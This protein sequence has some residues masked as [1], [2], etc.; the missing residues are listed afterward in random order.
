MKKT[1]PY[2][3]FIFHTEG[4]HLAARDYLRRRGFVYYRGGFIILNNH[5]IGSYRRIGIQTKLGSS[6]DKALDDLLVE[7]YGYNYSR[8]ISL[9][10]AK[11]NA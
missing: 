2:V 9:I 1:E 8:S 3:G 11:E 10:R 7:W 4:E 6:L 5:I